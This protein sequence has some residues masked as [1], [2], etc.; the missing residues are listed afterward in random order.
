MWAN[1]DNL[2]TVFRNTLVWRNDIRDLMKIYAVEKKVIVS[3]SETVAIQRHIRKW[4]TY[5]SSAVV[6]STLGS[7]LHESTPFC[8]V[9][10]KEILQQLHAVSSGRNQA[11]LRKSKIKCRRRNYE[12]CS[13]QLLRLPDHGEE[14]THCDEVPQWQKTHAAISSKLLKKPEHVNNSSYEVEIAEA[15]IEHKETIFHSSIGSSFFNTQNCECWSFTTNSATYSV[16]YARSNSWKW[17][18]IRCILLFLKKNW[19]IVSHLNETGR[20]EVAIKWLCR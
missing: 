9:H 3:T 20:A 10:A 12:A 6:L 8:W 11:R 14:P 5:S 17:T 18:Q 1:F 16:M 4:N 13:Q 7:C 19:K 2:P 15:Q